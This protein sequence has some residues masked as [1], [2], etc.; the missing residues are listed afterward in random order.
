MNGCRAPALFLKPCR[1][2][3]APNKQLDPQIDPGNI[4]DGHPGFACSRAKVKKIVFADKGPAA[5]L[6]SGEGEK[7]RKMRLP[8][9][10]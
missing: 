7:A 4:A 9:M 3:I 1:S 6:L 10:Q 5:F 8:S 2:G